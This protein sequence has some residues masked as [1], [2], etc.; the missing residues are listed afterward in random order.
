MANEK[1]LTILRQ[2]VEIWNRWRNDQP[3]L[4]IDG[5]TVEI[6]TFDVSDESLDNLFQLP[7]GYSGIDLSRA[8][9]SG[10]DLKGINFDG[11]DLSE[12]DLGGTSLIGA[13]LTRA[14][15]Q[16][17]NLFG[18]NLSTAT[19]RNA[20][21]RGA[22]LCRAVLTESDLRGAK[23]DSLDI[24]YAHVGST[25]FANHDLHT[26]RGLETLRHFGPSLMSTEILLQSAGKVPELFLQGIG[27]PDVLIQ[28][29]PSL[30]GAMRPIQ[31]Y[32]C[33]ISYS[34]KDDAF[35]KRLHKRMRAEHL[36]VWFA[37]EDIK[38]GE[39]LYEQIDRAIQLHDRLLLVLSEHSI[40]S[41]WVMTEIRRARRAE[42]KEQRRKLFPIRLVDIDTLRDW[43]CFDVDH[44]KDLAVDV[45]EYF[46]PDFSNWKDHD[47]FEAAFS[48]LL[49]DLKGAGTKDHP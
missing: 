6:G 32:S 16:K 5:S 40:Q 20:D 7:V 3:E 34:T 15:L 10:T 22:T 23:L 33:F 48:R 43:V 19:L 44:G 35:A 26:V 14:N 46:L 18:A 21:L 42:L 11:V 47:A 12:A 25:L 36:R 24:R 28:Y 31:Y 39:K 13:N 4:V 37:P 9:L 41:E 17:A 49:R 8:D 29:L 30:A 1:Y 27:V 38:G 2:G 45:R